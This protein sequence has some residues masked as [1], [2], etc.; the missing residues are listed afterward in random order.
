M[1]HALTEVHPN[2]RP[3][4]RALSR[5]VGP[6]QRTRTV[7]QPGALAATRRLTG[8]LSMRWS[9]G[10]DGR[11]RCTWHQPTPWETDG[12]AGTSGV[13]LVRTPRGWSASRRQ[14]YG[15]RR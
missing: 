12:T 5:P 1:T 4:R 13:A 7:R 3:A 2:A 8:T 9:M 11:L 10:P 15:P 6:N 14:V